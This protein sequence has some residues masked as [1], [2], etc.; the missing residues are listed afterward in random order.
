MMIT[1][2]VAGITGSVDSSLVVAPSLFADTVRGDWIGV[3]MSSHRRLFASRTHPTGLVFRDAFTKP[4]GI[5]NTVGIIILFV[6]PVWAIV[7]YIL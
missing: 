4:G 5:S 1:S 7:L 6:Y 2:R 3:V